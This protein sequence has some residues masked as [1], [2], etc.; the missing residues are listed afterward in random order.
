[1][2]IAVVIMALGLTGCNDT[3]SLAKQHMAENNAAIE[4]EIRKHLTG[5]TNFNAGEVDRDLEITQGKR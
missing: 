4:A 3:G 2:A 1:M 5:M